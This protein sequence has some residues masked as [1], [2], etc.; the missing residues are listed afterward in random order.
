MYRSGDMVKYRADG[1]IEFIARM[2]EQVKVR[3]YR[4]ELSEIEAVL[5]QLPEVEE[6]AV[7]ARETAAG[8]RQLVA[9]V[10][11][12]KPTFTANQLRS[13]LRQKLPDYMVPTALVTLGRL[14]LTANGKVDKRALAHLPCTARSSRQYVAA[15]SHEE[16]VLV[17]MWKELMGL[18]QVGVEDDFFE[19]GGHSLLATQVTAKVRQAFDVEIPLRCVFDNP[20]IAALAAIIDEMLVE[21]M[22][23]IS[24]EEAEQFLKRES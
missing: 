22:E 14:P 8:D 4:V 17:E 16:K 11:V 7:I 15:R 13:F 18:R 12:N 1:T 20:T 21:K 6:S 24:D 23:Q 3:G 19:I 10:T 5:S 9:Y 2:D